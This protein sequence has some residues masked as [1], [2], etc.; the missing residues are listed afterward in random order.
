[1]LDFSFQASVGCKI[2]KCVIFHYK[3][4]SLFNNKRDW[5]VRS[6]IP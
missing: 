1:M 3:S 6:D 5:L 4:S 2:A